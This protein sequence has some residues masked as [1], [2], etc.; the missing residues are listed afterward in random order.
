KRL[1]GKDALSPTELGRETGLSQQLLSGWLRDARR[2][3]KVAED[4]PKKTKKWTV[5]EKARFVLEAAA[6]NAEELT[7]LLLRKG[8]KLGELEQ[9]RLALDDRE[10]ASKVMARR[11]RELEAD[12]ARKEK[13]LAEAAA[14][15]ILKKKVE[16]LYP[17]A[18]DDDT[19][20]ENE[21]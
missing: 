20:D 11:M 12:L 18:E 8:V 5:E 6:L 16:G 9:W 21:K 7:E 2:L 15:L 4:K 3:P 17:A 14:L 19:D 1:I 10:V 13:A